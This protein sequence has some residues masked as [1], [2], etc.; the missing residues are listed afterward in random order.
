[1]GVQITAR[2]VISFFIIFPFVVILPIFGCLIVAPNVSY[3]LVLLITLLVMLQFILLRDIIDFGLGRGPLALFV[4]IAYFVIMMI[5][6]I[7]KTFMPN[8]NK[9]II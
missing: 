9:F 3:L 6:S 4:G 8:T 7:L 1:M 2:W 5:F